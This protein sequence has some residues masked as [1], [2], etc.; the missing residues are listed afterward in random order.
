MADQYSALELQAFKEEISQLTTQSKIRFF[1]CEEAI[2]QVGY[3]TT[4]ST[5]LQPPFAIVSPQLHEK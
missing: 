1:N 5:H 2:K 4:I 3:T